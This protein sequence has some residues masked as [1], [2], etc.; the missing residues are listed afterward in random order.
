MGAQVSAHIDEMVAAGAIDDDSAAL[1]HHINEAAVRVQFECLRFFIEPPRGGFS[2]QKAPF[3]GL[4]T[5][6][7]ASTPPTAAAERPPRVP[8]HP[9]TPGMPWGAARRLP[10]TLEKMP[11]IYQ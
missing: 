11:P 3:H 6:P 9:R 10:A 7:C 8:L 4:F 1:E 5:P 2:L